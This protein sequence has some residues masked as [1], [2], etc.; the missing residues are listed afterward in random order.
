MHTLSSEFL[1]SRAIN[2]VVPALNHVPDVV[3]YTL[4]VTNLTDRE[5]WASS[6]GN[7]QLYPGQPFNVMAAI[8]VRTP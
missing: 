8:R 2:D 1:Q 6:L 5:Y 4:N 7:R 3:A